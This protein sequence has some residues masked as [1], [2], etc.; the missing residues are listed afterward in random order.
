MSIVKVKSK[1]IK[2]HNENE[3]VPGNNLSIKEHA[4][5]LKTNQKS[6]KNRFNFSGLKN[7]ILKNAKRVLAILDLF[8]SK[9]KLKT[10]SKAYK[11]N[12]H[13]VQ[14]KQTEHYTGTI[15]DNATASEIWNKYIGDSTIDDICK[16]SWSKF[17]GEREHDADWLA[18]QHL[19]FYT[20]KIPEIESNVDKTMDGKTRKGYNDQWFAFINSKYPKLNKSAEA[21]ST[22]VLNTSALWKEKNL[23]GSLKMKVE[24]LKEFNKIQSQKLIEA[25]NKAINDYVQKH[26]ELN[27]PTTEKLQQL[28]EEFREEKNKVTHF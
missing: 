7:N 27:L 5:S 18:K 26:P 24:Q 21:T 3:K 19:N 10:K 2:T 6:N 28:Y 23:S 17:L 12:D 8:I 13:D 9:E 15:P 22:F 25:T 16:A 1:L 14:L 20:T 11:I 4:A